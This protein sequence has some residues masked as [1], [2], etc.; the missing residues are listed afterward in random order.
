VTFLP[1]ST[2]TIPACQISGLAR[3]GFLN[4]RSWRA[5]SLKDAS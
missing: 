5:C 4:D 1:N 2:S 3:H